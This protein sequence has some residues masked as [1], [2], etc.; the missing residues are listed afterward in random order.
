MRH[1]N[2][3]VT[4]LNNKSADIIAFYKATM[5]RFSEE[6]IVSIA[7]LK[8]LDGVELRALWVS[9]P[10]AFKVNNKNLGCA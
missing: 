9:I 8:K 7:S 10:A 4:D 6:L 5:V 3:I 2:W 1:S